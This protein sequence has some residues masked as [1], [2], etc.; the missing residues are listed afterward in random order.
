MKLHL[1]CGKLLISDFINIDI[2]GNA[3]MNF[4]IKNLDIFTDNSIDEIYICHCL[5]HLSRKEV[6]CTLLE[7]KRVLKNG[8]ILRI[9]VPDLDSIISLVKENS[10][11]IHI[12]TGLLYGGQKN[13]YD[14]HKTGY[15]FDT[16]SN[17]LIDIGFDNIQKYDTWD[18]LGVNYD[19]YSKSYI[20][21]MDRSGK[22]MSLNVICTKTNRDIVLSNKSKWF[23]GIIKSYDK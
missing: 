15:N 20:P 21:H 11:N 16:L 3:D 9:S 17:I 14:Y 13:E 2:S 4:D 23:F 8:G 12:V 5:E 22:L 7:Y 10:D 19:D 1:G 18:F 6:L